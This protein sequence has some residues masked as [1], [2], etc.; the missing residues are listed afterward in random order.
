VSSNHRCAVEN[1]ARRD[2]GN[3]A[4][5]HKSGQAGRSDVEYRTMPRKAGA[6]PARSRHC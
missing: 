3:S 5:R 6:N 1:V 4:G 2:A